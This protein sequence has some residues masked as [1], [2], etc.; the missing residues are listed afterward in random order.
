MKKIIALVVAIVMMAAMAV[1]A[2]AAEKVEG[3]N[4]LKAEHQLGT[5]T[6]I[7]Y[8]MSQK[9][10]ITIPQGINFDPKNADE[11]T[12]VITVTDKLI[13]DNY[14]LAADKK[15][16]ISAKPEDAGLYQE[17]HQAAG[18]Y[19][20]EYETNTNADDVQYFIHIGENEI[21]RNEELASA[22]TVNGSPKVEVDLVFST[23][24]TSQVAKFKDTIVYTVAIGD[25]T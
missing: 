25:R 19:L 15:L 4:A 23:Q 22:T 21:D 13:I 7:T 3:D 20:Y 1:P 14:S 24:G 12:G 11:I 9:Y 10:E 2:F 18:W 5:G 8:G 6:T 16:S 17:D